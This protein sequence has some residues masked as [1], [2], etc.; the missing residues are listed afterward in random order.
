MKKKIL[1]GIAIV[2]LV[3]LIVIGN[4]YYPAIQSITHKEIAT[5]D[6]DLTLVLGGGGNSG[7]II[8]DSAVVVI[9]TKMI[10]GIIITK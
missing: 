10:Y 2:F 9:D 5:I 6:P 4:I 3:V 8:G 1:V 7:I